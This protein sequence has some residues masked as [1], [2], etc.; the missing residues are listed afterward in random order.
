MAAFRHREVTAGSEVKPVRQTNRIDSDL[1]LPLTFLRRYLFYLHGR[2]ISSSNSQFRSKR[3]EGLKSLV[4]VFKDRSQPTLDR[5]CVVLNA[6]TEANLLQLAAVV[7]EDLRTLLPI[8]P[9][10]D[11]ISSSSSPSPHFIRNARKTML[12]FGPGIG[13]G[14]EIICFPIASR[15]QGLGSEITVLTGYEGLWNPVTG[16]ADIKT[17]HSSR[18][19]I[20]Q[21]RGGWDL[22]M[23]IDFENPGL[24]P[25]ISREI[26]VDRYAEISLGVRSATAFDRRASRLHRMPSLDPYFQN[27]YYSL[28]HIMDWLG[29]PDTRNFRQALV[30]S[31]AR[32][33]PHDFVIL[34]SPFTSE[35]NASLRYWG[36]LLKSVA[37]TDVGVTVRFQIETGS[38]HTTEAFAIELAKI[39]AASAPAGVHFELVNAN[40][41]SA[42]LREIFECLE[43]ADMVLAA[44]SF[45]AHAAPAFGVPATIIARD[46]VENWRVP[47]SSNFYFKMRDSI[48]AVALSIRALIRELTLADSPDVPSVQRQ[49]PECQ[50]LQRASDQVA[51]SLFSANPNLE[52][53]REDW[54]ACHQAYCRVAG[55]LRFWPTY[56]DSMLNDELYEHLIGPW[57]EAQA[58]DSAGWEEALLF[59]LQ[60]RFQEWHNSNL[61]KYLNGFTSSSI[62][63][64]APYAG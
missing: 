13:I 19:F 14:D 6:L 24:W 53:I 58:G 43:R 63:R 17:Y 5:I 49:R 9:P 29:A 12:A 59:H 27:F 16:V 46:G 48:S 18:E 64:T 34:V 33:N 47:D 35:F 55:E 41:R 40:G 54:I 23:M 21:I 38:N 2:P 57:P 61:Q 28:D 15:L 56:F 4:S 51:G 32:A 25:A 22:V 60:H 45:L 20:E 50:A 30:R 36:G 37:P 52:H 11:V 31:A 62:T 1:E 10:R 3:L 7:E 42:S 44:D 8:P 26:S 39:A